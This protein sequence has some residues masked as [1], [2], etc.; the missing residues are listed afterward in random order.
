MPFNVLLASS[1]SQIPTRNELFVGVI[2][3]RR[4]VHEARLTFGPPGRTV[5][6]SFSF[7]HTYGDRVQQRDLSVGEPQK[8]DD[9]HEKSFMFD[10]MLRLSSG[11]RGIGFELRNLR[12]GDTLAVVGL[13]E[14]LFLG[15]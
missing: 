4:L 6:T 2:S 5:G 15:S 1:P 12:L 13:T 7:M 9:S 3:D 11:H 14:S 8:F 10:L